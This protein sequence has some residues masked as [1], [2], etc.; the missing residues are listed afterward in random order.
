M[1]RKFNEILIPLTFRKVR[2]TP[3][4]VLDRMP[5]K[6][7][8]RVSEYIHLYTTYIVIDCKLD[9]NRVVTLLVGCR[10]L[11]DLEYCHSSFF[12]ININT[13]LQVEIFREDANLHWQWS[14]LQKLSP[15][16]NRPASAD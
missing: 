7:C 6:I 4:L 9:W 16:S 10:R 1:S 3:D 8:S 14:D 11:K 2:L 12:K 13:V 5:D 15:G